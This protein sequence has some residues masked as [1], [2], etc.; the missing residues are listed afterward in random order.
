MTL[1]KIGNSALPAIT[2]TFSNWRPTP[3]ADAPGCRTPWRTRR[4]SPR[5]LLD[6][7]RR[8]LRLRGSLLGDRQR[9]ERRGGLDVR[10]S[11]R[12]SGDGR[13]LE[14]DAVLLQ[15]V[16]LTL[17][18]RTERLH[19]IGG[20]PPNV[21]A[22]SEAVP[23]MPLVLPRSSSS[24]TPW[25]LNSDPMRLAFSRYSLA[26]SPNC[27]AAWFESLMTVLENF[28]K[29]V[30]VAPMDCWALEA[31]FTEPTPNFTT[32]H[33]PKPHRRRRPCRSCP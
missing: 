32:A 21:A 16:E 33:Q 11:H 12:L 10:N 4:P 7:V 30:S 22:R 17:E 15:R 14:A 20:G 26:D 18:R 23:T 6:Q 9:L 19:G 29:T 13:R 5:L 24:A 28:P 1:V 8:G 31:D 25:F 27:L 2:L 3:A